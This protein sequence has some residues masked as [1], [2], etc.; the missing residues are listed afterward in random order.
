MIKN[1]KWIR[2]EK[3]NAA[4]SCPVFVKRFVT[5][6]PVKAKL[7]LTAK[8]VYYAELNHK[9]VGRFILAPG[10]TQ[11]SSRLQY[12]TYDITDLIIEGENSLEIT[13]A[14]GWYS[15][16]EW[17]AEIIGE[18]KL[19]Y[20]DG[21]CV[22]YGTDSSWKIGEGPVLFAHWY[23]GEIYD[24]TKCIS[25]LKDTVVD[26]SAT[27]DE[28]IAQ[29]GEDVVERE[30]ISP[31]S[32]FQTPKGETVIDFGQNLAGYPELNLSAMAGE[33]VSLS[34]AEVLDKDGNFYTENYRTA[35]CQ[36]KYTCKEGNQTYK[37][38]CAFYGF[39]YV[40]V[41]SF[42]KSASLALDTF[43]AVAVY[44]NIRKTGS[45]SCSNEKL[46][47]LFSNVF[48]GQRSNFL[49]IPTD[50]PQRDERIGWTGDAQV[51]S[52]TACY[53]FD[54]LKFFR[55]WLRDME[56]TQQIF[57]HVGNVV[58]TRG[59]AMAA[60]WSDAAVIIPWNVYRIY[61]DKKFLAE[62]IGMM[63]E[64]VDCIGRISEEPY[65]WRG[66]KNVRQFGDWLATDSLDK[67]RNGNFVSTS[68]SGATRPDFLQA[69]FYAYDTEILIKA[70][71]TLGEDCGQYR[72]LHK[73]IIER[74]RV[75]YPV[76]YTQTECIIA[77][78]FRLTPDPQKTIEDLVEKIKKNG[79]RMSTGFVG[80]PHILHALSENGRVDLAYSLL[81]QEEFPSWLYSV[82]LGATT[83][84]EHWDGI[85]KDGEM[86]SAKM[87]SFNHYAYGSFADWI[88]EVAAGIGQTESSAGFSEIVIAPHPDKRLEWLEASL[89][90]NKGT[91]VSKWTYTDDGIKYEITVPDRAIIIVDGKRHSVEKGKYTLK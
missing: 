88:Y 86:W 20:S 17:F 61:G 68:H 24:A 65:T 27:T 44:S 10:Y 40:R 33:T 11:Y 50:C 58:P 76:Y 91:I 52:K 41:D 48:W 83:M 28:L 35:K 16:V 54:C 74:F 25:N 4:G 9:R 15:E 80:T 90:T 3:I 19:E 56:A 43:T 18:I 55:K 36:Y 23:D 1:Q 85:N 82:N 70:L 72:E 64:H 51:F 42:A 5:A 79:D 59:S 78:H 87:N 12:Q 38:R 22:T 75:D 13:V 60:A 39:R 31:I 32:I 8:G 77:L 84:W 57:G 2:A 45:L 26:A 69:A 53:N 30:R 47:Q 14:G 66:G 34:F 67:D 46:N 37:P 62:M 71:E 63:K 6:L 7:T 73:K 81:L 89:E 21:T 29:E 49:D